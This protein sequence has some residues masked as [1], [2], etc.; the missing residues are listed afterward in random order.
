MPTL[1][2]EPMEM[3]KG[4]DRK[5]NFLSGGGGGEAETKILILRLV[6]LELLAGGW[7]WRE[8]QSLI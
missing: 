3:R 2:W 1:S 7:W 8:A 5:P 4:R 6:V